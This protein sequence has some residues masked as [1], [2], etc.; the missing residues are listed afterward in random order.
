MCKKRA[1]VFGITVC[2]SGYCLAIF[3]QNPSSW[4]YVRDYGARTS[5]TVNQ[6]ISDVGSNRT[7]R[8]VF[9]GGQ[10]A[11]TNNVTFTTNI[12]VMIT[13]GS[14][15]NVSAGVTGTL[16]SASFIADDYLCFTGSGIVNGSPAFIYRYTDWGTASI[17]TGLTAAQTPWASTINGSAYGLT[18]VSSVVGTNGVDL[19]S[20]PAFR[21]YRST[22]QTITNLVYT[23]IV[24]DS[25]NLNIGNGWVAGTTNSFYAPIS[26]VYFLHGAGRLDSVTDSKGVYG[27]IHING[28]VVASSYITSAATD[29][30]S[31][32]IGYLGYMLA[33][34]YADFYVRHQMSTSTTTQ[35]GSAYT[36]FEGYYIGK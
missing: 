22:P 5:A 26:G 24:F 8:F 30:L 23:K 2:L 6:L 11:F 34:Q 35:A 4:L 7:V 29:D 12:S 21:V 13:E 19:T 17:G 31:A 32:Q 25:I 1:M 9:D 20:V 27:Q 33:G 28:S 36:F 3:I 16:S 18:N 14:A 10:W 15:W